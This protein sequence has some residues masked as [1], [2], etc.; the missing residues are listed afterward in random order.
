MGKAWGLGDRSVPRVHIQAT[1]LSSDVIIDP[2]V[3]VCELLTSGVQETEPHLLI[4]YQKLG[5]APM[6]YKRPSND[7]HPQP[8]LPELSL[9]LLFSRGDRKTEIAG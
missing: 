1:G 4:P 9:L 8:G 5:E 2:F 6:G 7:F 3:H